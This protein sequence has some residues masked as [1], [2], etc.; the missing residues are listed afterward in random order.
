MNNLLQDI[1][2]AI[3]LFL[4]SPGLTLVAIITLALGIG[5]NTAIFSMVNFI[6][7][8]P[9]PFPNSN[10][11]VA[12]W[13]K[14]PDSDRNEVAPANF[15]DWSS[16]STSFENMAAISFWSANLTGVD[17]P[18]RLQGFQVSP[19]LFP[20]LAVTPYLGR[21]F[22]P[23]EATP[24]KDQ[25][26]VLSFELWQRRFGADPHII[27]STI[28][29]NGIPHTVVG[30]MPRGF[31]VYRQ[32]DLW[33]PLAFTPEE[34]A[35]REFHY[36]IVMGRLK[37]S[38]TIEQAQGEMSSIATNLQRIYP[39]TNTDQGI[40]LI[41]LFDQTVVNIRPALVMLQAA[42]AFILLIACVNLANLMLAR[43]TTRRKEI[44]IRLAM[45]A[46]RRR[47]I[48]Q[49]LTETTLLALLGGVAALVLAIWCVK[50]Q[51]ANTPPDILYV[52]PRLSQVGV[53]PLAFI[54]TLVVSVLVGI[55][56][57]VAP[58]MQASSSLK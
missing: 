15:V 33:V 35:N 25:I 4:K 28:S 39:K 44:A 14:P 56:F 38:V 21:S 13:E 49:L 24:G 30:V 2:F 19:S 58:A 29:L 41:S 7:L 8:N 37:P 42:V 17:T 31:Q 54:F 52:L 32:A 48:R 55:L 36:L 34:K 22:L 1:R 40:K 51:I 27:N 12:A 5:L 50:L 10:R 57:G 43:S 20:M 45:G 9:F 16:Q 3:R 46:S 23:D 26:A 47:L 18:E 53:D 6:L 11:L